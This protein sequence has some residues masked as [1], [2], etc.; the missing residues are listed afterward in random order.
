MEKAKM[1]G[2]KASFAA[3]EDK[4]LQ[5]VYAPDLKRAAKSAAGSKEAFEA[6][7][8]ES[9]ESPETF[10]E[11][12]AKELAWIKPWERTSE[13]GLPDFKFFV[14][15]LMNPC[16]NMIDRHIETGAG[17]RLALIWEGENGESKFFTYRMLLDAVLRASTLLRSLEFKKGDTLAMFLPNLPE[18]VIFTLACYRLGIIFNTVFSGF[19]SKALHDRLA[20]FGPSVL[21]TADGAVRRGQRLPLKQTVDEALARLEVQPK[22][23]LVVRRL[24]DPVP[25]DPARDA[26]L[27]ELLSSLK[28]EPYA[29]AIEANETGLVI[30]SSGTTGAPKGVMHAGVAFVVNNYVHT[31]YHMDFHPDDVFWCTADIG[32]LTSHIWGIVGAFSNGVTTVFTEGALDFPD[33]SRVYKTIERYKVTKLFTAPTLVRMLMRFGQDALSPYDVSSLDVI[34]FVGEPLNP[35]AWRWCYEVLGKRRIYINNTWGQTE[36]AGTPLASCAWITE[37]KPGSSGKPYLGCV[38]NIVDD[39]GN[40]LPAGMPGNL[41]LTKPFPM[42]LRGLWKERERFEKE[43]Y[44]KI[45]GMYF[46]YDEALEDQDGHFWVLGRT[47]DVINVA[48]HRISTMEIESA[49]MHADGVAEV[50]V[51][52]ETDAIKGLV[53]VAFVTLKQDMDPSCTM[54]ERIHEEVA[55]TIGRIAVPKEIYFTQEMPKTPSGKILRRLLRELITKGEVKSDTSG[56]EDLSTLERLKQTLSQRK[57]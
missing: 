3:F 5:S 14:G 9:Q 31:R 47:D 25:M 13:G 34:G 16:I 21:I 45:H 53:P 33:I 28:P 24:G 42:L 48:G 6:L 12:A 15:G 49:I 30:Y 46:T 2:T 50:A 20:R 23:V 11:K 4:Q 39:E 27:D 10:W 43:Y 7:L 57:D 55:R 37:M 40:P 26:Y 1:S 32:W 38:A 18:T 44:G 8:K 56:L 35:E 19:S 51:V 22:K 36:T 54:K 41:V 52:G 17:N 29:E